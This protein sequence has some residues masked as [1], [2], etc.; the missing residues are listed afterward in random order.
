MRMIVMLY[1][2][3]IHRGYWDFLRKHESRDYDCFLIGTN[4]IKA[5]GP[6]A[7]YVLKKDVAIRGM[8]ESV[9]EDCVGRYFN[10]NSVE[11]LVPNVTTDSV[12]IQTTDEDITSLALTAFFPN[13]IVKLDTTRL[14]YDRKGVERI[15]E[16]PTTECT[17]EE[18]AR[19][20]MQFAEM[21]A[22]KSKDWWL[23]VGAL[24]SRDGMPILIAYNA[25]AL[26]PDLPNILGDPRSIYSRGENTE[27]TLVAHAERDLV[28]QA[29]RD[30]ISLAGTDAY[31]T[32]FPCVPCA[33]SLA[34]AGVRRL[35]F[36]KGYSRLESLDLLLSKG[37][38]VIRVV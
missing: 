13:A 37:V 27:D 6:N 15:D 12:H 38:E 29:A 7:A 14:R 28:A 20:L 10:F 33:A 4:A 24:I 25:A 36:K 26:D 21:E 23:S 3:V 22:E 8:P 31:V 2:P 16:V 30:G 18:T 19:Q 32:H 17:S 1:M 35:F 9:I 11:M 5:L 34:R